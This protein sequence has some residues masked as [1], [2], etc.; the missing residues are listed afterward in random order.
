MSRDLPAGMQAEVAGKKIRPLVLIK[1]EFDSGSLRLWNG[2]RPLTFNAEVYTGSGNLLNISGVQETQVLKAA[3]VTFTLSGIDA[4]A[5]SIALTE[6]YQGRPVTLWFGAMD[7]DENIIDAPFQQFQGYLDVMT[8]E[9]DGE[10]ATISVTAE[11]ELLDLERPRVRRYT[12]KDQEMDYRGD[13]FF[14]F[15]EGLQEKEIPA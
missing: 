4:S 8:M 7:A 15:V 14:E 10:T 1:F 12:D 3:G 2:I 11:N 13:R 5:I 6:D 9:D